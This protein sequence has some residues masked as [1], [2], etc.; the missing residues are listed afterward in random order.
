M[1]LLPNATMILNQVCKM[2]VMFPQR[3]QPLGINLR[4]KLGRP[5]LDTTKAM[6]WAQICL[7]LYLCTWI[8]RKCL[9]VCVCFLQHIQWFRTNMCVKTHQRILINANTTRVS[10]WIPAETRLELPAM[11][12][13][14]NAKFFFSKQGLATPGKT[15]LQVL[16]T[17]ALKLN[18]EHIRIIRNWGMPE[19]WNTH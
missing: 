17:Q 16:E 14:S 9:S 8:W 10:T 15:V 7:P 3:P 19:M 12:L 4:Q 13:A 5:H 11:C 18:T 6:K 2:P 1:F